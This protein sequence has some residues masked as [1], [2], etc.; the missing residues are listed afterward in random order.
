VRLLPGITG[1]ALY[2]RYREISIF[3]L[4]SEG[5]GMP[6]TITE[7]MYFGGAIVAGIS[8]SVQYQLDNGRCGCLHNA[9]DLNLLSD[10]LQ[11]LM[12]SNAL[13]ETYM[14]LA[15][16]RMLSLF[17][18]EQYFPELEFQFQQLVRA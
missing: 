13:R 17:V 9:S 10:H 7:A 8:G 1:E 16:N 4:P 5:E 15:R 11:T 14:I 2:R 12:A 18:W 3:A 6:T